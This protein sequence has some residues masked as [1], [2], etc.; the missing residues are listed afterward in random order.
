[1]ALPQLSHPGGVHYQGSAD[2]VILMKLSAI[3]AEVAAPETP[4]LDKATDVVVTE[5]DYPGSKNNLQLLAKMLLSVGIQNTI[6]TV[7]GKQTLRTLA[8]RGHVQDLLSIIAE[9][10]A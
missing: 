4:G 5:C 6:E 10:K 9:V 8:L 3:A 2:A 1:L 7:D